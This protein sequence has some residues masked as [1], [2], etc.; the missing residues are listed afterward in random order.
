[1]SV[2]AGIDVDVPVGNGYRVAVIVGGRVAVGGGVDVE[3][4]TTGVVD[5]G[6]GVDVGRTATRVGPGVRVGRTAGGVVDGQKG[7]GTTVELMFSSRRM[8]SMMAGST[9]GMTAN[10]QAL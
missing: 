6:M 5:G 7:R 10:G 4:P 2:A 9:A 3:V 1:V 8:S